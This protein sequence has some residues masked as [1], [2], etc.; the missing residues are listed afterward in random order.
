MFAD[1]D[2]ADD[3]A[4]FEESVHRAQDLL[5][6]VEDACKTIGLC[7]NASKTKLMHLNSSSVTPLHALDDC[8]I[9]KV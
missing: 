9:E 1:L 4:L 5:Y 2:Y 8:I 3:I 6:R 7:L